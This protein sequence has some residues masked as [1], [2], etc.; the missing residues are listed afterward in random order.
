MVVIQRAQIEDGQLVLPE[1]L[2]LPDGTT[3]VVSIEIVE[4]SVEAAVP[5]GFDFS[6][7]P[8]FGAWA[9]RDEMADS[10]A[11]VNE[12]RDTWQQRLHTD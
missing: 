1:P 9:D 11:W 2:A 4:P 10:A 6:S 3:V 12:Q 8:F 7:E 5:S